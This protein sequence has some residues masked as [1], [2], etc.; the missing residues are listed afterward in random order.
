MAREKKS[1]HKV[2][3]TEG[4]R[5]II[6][7]LFQEF[8]IQS[9]E[10]IQDALKGL[11]SGTIKAMMETEMDEHLSYQKSQ[12]SD[13]GDYSNGY[14]RKQVHSRYGTMDIPGTLGLQ[15]HV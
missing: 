8:D 1:V 15:S 7:Q 3:M 5:R 6:H 9:A 2:V 4:K 12:R 11:L 10:D 13:S 14:K